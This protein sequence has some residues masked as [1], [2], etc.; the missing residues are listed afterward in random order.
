MVAE[1]SDVPGTPKGTMVA[2]GVWGMPGPKSW[3][4][5]KKKGYYRRIFDSNHFPHKQRLLRYRQN[6]D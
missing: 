6:A 5:P 1:I 3:S 2:V 4:T